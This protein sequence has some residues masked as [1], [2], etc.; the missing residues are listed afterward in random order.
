[1]GLKLL[2]SGTSED[3]RER[4][5]SRKQGHK[6]VMVEAAYVCGT[7]KA[8]GKMLPRHRSSHNTPVHSSAIPKLTPTG[9]T[10]AGPLCPLLE[11][12]NSIVA[13]KMSVTWVPAAYLRLHLSNRDTA[14]P[15]ESSLW[16]CANLQ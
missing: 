16:I 12:V 13:H 10:H 5:L 7:Q 15:T 14:L 4:H 9:D 3:L 6:E 11:T 2:Y 8:A 1:M